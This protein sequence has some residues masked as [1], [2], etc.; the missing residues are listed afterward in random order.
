MK[1]D[2]TYKRGMGSAVLL[3]A[4]LAL[5]GVLVPC[6]PVILS[7][8]AKDANAGPKPGDE[9]KLRVEKARK[10]LSKIESMMKRLPQSSPEQ[11]MAYEIIRKDFAF[12]KINF[13]SKTK[14]RIG[15]VTQ[16]VY[17]VTMKKLD[18]IEKKIK[19]FPR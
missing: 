18:D 16:D 5:F 10:K 4:V 13:E 19:K 15:M 2:P 6:A 7:S 11:K 3:L 1:M 12:A 14:A 17:H 9:S 8:C